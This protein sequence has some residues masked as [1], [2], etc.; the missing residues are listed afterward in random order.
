MDV[1][2][3]DVGRSTT[4][5]L[6]LLDLVR[7]LASLAVVVWH[8]QHFYFI[9]LTLPA[10]FHRDEQPFYP[11]LSVLYEHGEG[12]VQLFFSLSGFVFFYQ[13]LTKIGDRSV[14][15]REFFVLRFSRLYPLHIV[16]L[17]AVAIG[18]L[19]ALTTFH[20]FVVYRC[21]DVRNFALNLFFATEWIPKGVCYSF[22]GPA[23]SLSVEVFLYAL[24]FLFAFVVPQGWK[25]RTIVCATVVLVGVVN[26]KLSTFYLIGSPIVCFFAG[27][28]AYLAWS[29]VNTKR[30]N[31]HLALAAASAVAILSLLKLCLHGQSLTMT[32]IVL[33]PSAIL[34]LAI[35]QDVF[36][37]CGKRTR[38]IGDISYSIYL[39]HFPLQL[40]IILL[41][42]SGLIHAEFD[43]PMTFIAFFGVVIVV[44]ALSYYRFELP[45]QRWIRKRYSGRRSGF[46][47]SEQAP[48]AIPGS[49]A[50]TLI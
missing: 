28:A 10:S 37:T 7:G 46:E 2:P 3:N 13:Y 50:G 32:Y 19:I 31:Q 22:N 5:R 24:F 18:Q 47:K 48:L 43:K 16:T 30:I 17:L 1:Q 36:P 41:V 45:A 12:A 27:G 23:W 20:A 6:Y 9:S 42:M 39:L 21:N 33:Y 34:A 49:G 38:L 25:S 8:Y 44:S 35:L 4:H 15:A 40:S 11:L 29:F 14:S 26:S